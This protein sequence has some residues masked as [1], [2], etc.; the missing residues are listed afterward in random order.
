LPWRKV[1]FCGKD[2][3]ICGQEKFLKQKVFQIAPKKE[4]IALA[5]RRFG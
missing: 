1:R 5:G 4:N 3:E 2:G